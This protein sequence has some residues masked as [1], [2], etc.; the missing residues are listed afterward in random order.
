MHMEQQ[1][2]REF[3]SGLSD[4]D[5]SEKAERSLPEAR[6]ADVQRG[7]RMAGQRRA[8]KLVLHISFR[9]KF[10]R[11]K[12]G[13]GSAS[14]RDHYCRSMAGSVILFF[15]VWLKVLPLANSVFSENLCL[16]TFKSSDIVK[17]TVFQIQNSEKTDK[18]TFT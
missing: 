7:A 16:Y 1:S 5:P 8:G 11:V 12:K 3:I 4:R 10:E 9:R 2:F 18:K 6:S 15:F 17:S 13:A 14:G